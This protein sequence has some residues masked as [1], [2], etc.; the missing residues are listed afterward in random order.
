MA[1]VWTVL[2]IEMAAVLVVAIVATRLVYR[3]VAG[4]GGSGRETA[5]ATQRAH[6]VTRRHVGATASR[7]PRDRVRV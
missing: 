6:R 4:R 2:A 7:A 5:R 3:H 1:S